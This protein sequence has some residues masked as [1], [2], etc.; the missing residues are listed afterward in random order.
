MS[1]RYDAGKVT[2]TER[3]PQGGIRANAFFTRAGIF[4]YR[5][6][7]GSIQKELRHP[8]QVFSKESLDTLQ[9]ATI[10]CLHPNRVTS[11]DY[12]KLSIGHAR[13]PQREDTADGTAYVAGVAV[14]QDAEAV[15]KVDSGKLVEFSCGYS[16]DVVESP[17]EYQGQKYDCIQTNIRYNHIAIGPRNWGRAGS[18]VA[19]RLDSSGDMFDDKEDAKM[20]HET[21]DGIKF[22]VGSA[23]HVQALRKQRDTLQGR[24]DTLTAE[25]SREVARAD[26]AEGERDTL[27]TQ[28]SDATSPGN[29]DKLVNDRLALRNKAAA[30]IG[31]GFSVTR[32]DDK[33]NDVTKTSQEIMIEAVQKTDSAFKADD[34]T[35]ADYLRGRFEQLQVRNDSRGNLQA[36][37]ALALNGKGP[38]GKKAAKEGKTHKDR[39]DEADQK[40][41][42]MAEQPLTI[43][44]K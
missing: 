9:D 37:A 1:I 4:E 25:L 24:T 34:N 10:T 17:G 20:D 7:D 42:E 32:K 31:K 6:P 40:R 14:I 33:G 2:K 29:V 12:K 8:D 16:C 43:S 19:L 35:S 3:T 5:R 23:E 13:D 39:R 44:K 41:R 22:V 18:S 38:D 21:I 36:A 15:E 27:A 11:K 30:I 28:R 26:A